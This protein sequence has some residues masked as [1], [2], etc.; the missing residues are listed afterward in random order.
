MDVRRLGFGRVISIFFGAGLFASTLAAP[1]AASYSSTTSWTQP[2]KSVWVDSAGGIV[3]V[4][5]TVIEKR[6]ASNGSVVWTRNI[7]PPADGF[8]YSYRLVFDSANNMYVAGHQD[9]RVIQTTVN[10]VKI[11]SSGTVL[12]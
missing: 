2:V 11:S 6:N 1:A 3:T 5:G 7:S 4:T 8:E 10:V 9:N 12:W